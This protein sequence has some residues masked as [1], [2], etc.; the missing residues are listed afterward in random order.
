[1]PISF[2]EDHISQIPALLMLEKLG[3][4][5][6]APDE[7]L[8]LRGG[9]LA[10][11][12]LEPVLRKQLA[13]INVVQVSS[14]RTTVFSEQNITAGIEALRN[15]PMD[16]G[17]MEAS[18]TVYDLL[19]L[20][21][22][23]EQIVDGDRKSFVLQYIDWKNPSNNVFHVTEEFA[24]SRTGMTDTYRPD[25]VLFVNGIPLCVIECKRPDVKDS[26]EQAISQHLRNQKED[27]IRSLYL[28]STLLLALNRQEGSYA[29]TA[30][31]EKF[32]AKWHEQFVDREEE[33]RYRQELD[34]IVNT[35]L[36]DEKLFGERF[37]YVRSSFE[38]L[39]TQPVTP[40]VQD[41]YLYNLCRP[42]R[43][44]Q[45]MYGFTLYDDGI[46]KVARYQQYFAVQQTMRRVRHIE[47]ERRHGGVIWHT[48]G[49]GK[50][51]TMVMLAQAIILEKE[52][53]NPK[54]ILVTDRTDLDR[55]ITGTFRK[56]QIRVEN[57][58]TG[59]KLV[60]LLN[61]KSDAV[62]TTIINKFETAVRSIRTP[63]T[64]PNIFVIIDEGHRSQY[65]EMSIKMVV[66]P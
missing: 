33:D 15:I 43:L 26:I 41:E 30:T 59:S 10:N 24:V 22:T 7:A 60:E 2:K 14:V 40:S 54:I 28:Y 42:V 65:G 18:Q 49:S 5:Y 38:E 62:I 21:K 25:I 48:Q 19:T 23:L 1:M 58:T 61:S 8:A 44:L 12:L 50:S 37:G 46:K 31:P 20:G 17:F 4:T 32:W 16:E 13:A 63:F 29:T 52:I 51:L 47:G 57:A 9:N 66:L 35:P 11:V 53:R 34:K 55:Q 27:G 3:Y 56:C 64:D 36:L 39:Y 45:L 6:L